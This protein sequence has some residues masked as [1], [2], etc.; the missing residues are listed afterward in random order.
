M[1]NEETQILRIPTEKK[2]LFRSEKLK[3][4]PNRVYSALQV[5]L[6]PSLT[7][8]V[9]RHSFLVRVAREETESAFPT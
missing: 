2:V 4:P 5:D 3:G 6:Y 9:H 8:I 1:L 7:V